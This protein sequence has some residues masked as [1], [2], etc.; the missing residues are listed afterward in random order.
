[1]T[2]FGFDIPEETPDLEQLFKLSTELEYSTAIEDFKID[3]GLEI[4]EIKKK[5]EDIKPIIYERPTK[6]NGL[7]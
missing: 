7:F 5:K 2:P 3:N 1:M 6:S 4:S